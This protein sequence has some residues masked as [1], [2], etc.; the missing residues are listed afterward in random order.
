MGDDL[1]LEDFF[2]TFSYHRST[3]LCSVAIWGESLQLEGTIESYHR[4]ITLD[5]GCSELARL[6]YSFLGVETAGIPPAFLQI[7]ITLIRWIKWLRINCGD[8]N[9]RL[10]GSGQS[11]CFLSRLETFLMT[12]FN[13][14]TTLKVVLG[15]SKALNSG[16]GFTEM[17]SMPF[18]M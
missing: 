13:F 7:D 2:K 4:Y 11:L 8:S 3:Q 16:S 15:S 17:R 5:N 6:V 18:N 1:Q 12:T 9:C 10:M 14:H